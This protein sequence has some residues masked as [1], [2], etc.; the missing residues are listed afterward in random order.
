MSP[1]SSSSIHSK[2]ILAGLPLFQGVPASLLH[3]VT[4]SARVVQ[5]AKGT[6]ILAQD[7]PVTRFFIIL[8][9]WCG[10]SKGN[11]EGQESILQI[12][13]RGAFLPEF[14]MALNAESLNPLNLVALTPMRL[15]M[16]SPVS[17]R[18][19]MEKSPTLAA[20]M[21]A[22]AV[23]RSRELRDHIEQLTLRTAEQRVG[24]FLL[25]MRS[26][27]GARGTDIVLPFEKTHIAS[28]LGI[29]PETLS[30]T[31]QFFKENGFVIERN[32]LVAPYRQA[33]CD[34]CDQITMRSCRFVHSDECAHTTQG[35][36]ATL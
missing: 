15:L 1:E 11:L 27:N 28:Y 29:K 19:V 36:A 8:E 4:A 26:D 32:H 35:D 20:N 3:E 34:Y 7:Q 22:A 33:L 16:L 9:G 24:R 13:E 31:L 6:V 17:L 2:D 30:R 23:E 18:D 25:Q 5:Y 10:A 12:F 14:D 21:L